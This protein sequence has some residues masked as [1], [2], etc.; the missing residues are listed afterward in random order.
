[1]QRHHEVATHSTD[2]K[3]AYLIRRSGAGGGGGGGALHPT[4]RFRWCPAA[5]SQR[6]EESHDF[7]A[8]VSG[9]VALHTLGN[10]LQIE[11]PASAKNS[12]SAGRGGVSNSK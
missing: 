5:R 8:T 7:L 11:G 2:P 4:L 1:M 9:A 10:I 6:I 12:K 3:R